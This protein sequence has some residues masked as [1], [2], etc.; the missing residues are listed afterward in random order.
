MDL[1]I[2]VPSVSKLI[3]KKMSKKLKIRTIKMKIK[4]Q[5]PKMETG[6]ALEGSLIIKTIM[7]TKKTMTIMILAHLEILRKITKQQ[8]LINK[9]KLVVN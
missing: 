5:M 4:V 8:P 7:M 6:V 9:I 3:K 1:M 2:L